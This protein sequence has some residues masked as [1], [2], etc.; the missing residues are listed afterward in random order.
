[1]VPHQQP[2]IIKRRCSAAAGSAEVAAVWPPPRY[3]CGTCCSARGGCFHPFESH[4]PSIAF[5][6][7]GRA[8]DRE[9]A[10]PRY[11][12]IHVQGQL[13]GRGS[14]PGAAFPPAGRETKSKRIS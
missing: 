4:L 13:G 3:L 10:G 5:S 2:Q 8:A 14:G 9:S 1:M 6:P 12:L 7:S 11:R